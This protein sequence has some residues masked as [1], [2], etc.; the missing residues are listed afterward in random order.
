MVIPALAT[1]TSIGPSS[2]SALA[3]ASS[4]DVESVTSALSDSE[5]SGPVPDR[6][7]TATL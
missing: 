2:F 5:P 3:I 4:S 7:V 6:T 1:R